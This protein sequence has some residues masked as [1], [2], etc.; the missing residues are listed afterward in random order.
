VG[1]RGLDLSQDRGGLDLFYAGKGGYRR[2]EVSVEGRQ[3]RSQVNTG[4][5][6]GGAGG[7][8]SERHLVVPGEG[9]PDRVQVVDAEPEQ[10]AHREFH[11]GKVDIDVEVQYAAGTQGV[12]P[13]SPNSAGP[14]IERRISPSQQAERPS[15]TRELRRG[16][17]DQ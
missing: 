14:L 10:G 16:R 8:R 15:A 1:D 6:V 4:E 9:V 2:S 17:P 3:V 12:Q 13:T 5:D 7:P 11:Q